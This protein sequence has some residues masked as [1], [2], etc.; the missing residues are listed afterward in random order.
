MSDPCMRCCGNERR[1]AWK[2]R[3]DLDAVSPT[4]RFSRPLVAGRV[5]WIDDGNHS[6]SQGIRRH[7]RRLGITALM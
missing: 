5:M 3:P 6:V 4:R 7:N 1:V 2:L